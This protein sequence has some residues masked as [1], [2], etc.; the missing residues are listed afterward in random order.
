M[1]PQTKELFLN[2][3]DTESASQRWDIEHINH[4]QLAKWDDPTKDMF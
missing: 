1:D 4:Q 2:K 3:C